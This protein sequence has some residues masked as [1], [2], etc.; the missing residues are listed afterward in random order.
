MK[1]LP[2]GS[3]DNTRTSLSRWASHSAHPQS[4][5]NKRDVALAPF[6]SGRLIASGGYEVMGRVVISTL[7]IV[8]ALS[9][10]V[11]WHIN[12]KLKLASS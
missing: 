7:L 10:V 6:L 5:I 1:W 4:R 11:G 2:T 12:Q 8:M 3:S 9:I